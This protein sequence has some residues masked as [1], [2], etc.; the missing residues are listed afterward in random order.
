[1]AVTPRQG[2]QAGQARVNI[3]VNIDE[4][5]RGVQLVQYLAGPSHAIEMLQGPILEYLQHEAAQRFSKQGDSS[6]PWKELTPATQMFRL[7]QG[8]NPTWP[9]NVRYGDMRAWLEHDRGALRS[10]GIDVEMTWPGSSG[11]E[12]KFQAAQ[13]GGT[14]DSGNKFP[15]RRVVEFQANDAAQVLVMM[16]ASIT[17]A[18]AAGGVAGF[19]SF[20]GSM[21]GGRETNAS[22]FG[23]R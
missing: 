16:E 19:S 12:N 11:E 22:Y 1:M 7:M 14:S 13:E 23:G 8:F 18:L 15:A 3:Q 6:G 9:I 21:T 10:M 17:V 5:M 2:R 4:A 20:H